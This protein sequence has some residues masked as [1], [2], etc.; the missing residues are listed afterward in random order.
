MKG[1]LGITTFS[2]FFFFFFLE[3]YVFIVKKVIYILEK[4][5]SHCGFCSD[6]CY[7]IKSRFIYIVL[8]SFIG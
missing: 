1:S 2:F 7:S 4:I 3:N 8:K 5:I 6:F